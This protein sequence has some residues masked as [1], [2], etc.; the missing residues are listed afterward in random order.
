MIVFEGCPADD[1]FTPDYKVQ[2]ALRN[3]PMLRDID[4]SLITNPD[5]QKCVLETADKYQIKVQRSVRK[6]G[7]TNGAT[8]QLA[9]KG[10]PTIVV[11]IPVRYTHAHY[12][13][14]AYEDYESAKELVS[15][16]LRDLNVEVYAQF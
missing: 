11:G 12:G 15:N 4:V 6:G 14:V 1:T 2:S 8:Y 9:Q 7:G 3:G 10:I 13:F 5:F 16:I